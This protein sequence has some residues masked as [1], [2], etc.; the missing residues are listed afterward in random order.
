MVVIT[1]IIVGGSL[2]RRDL[3]GT[4]EDLAI[5]DAAKNDKIVGLGP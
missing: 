2:R 5:V 3:L 4:S 1:I